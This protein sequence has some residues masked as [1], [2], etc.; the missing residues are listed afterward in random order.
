MILPMAFSAD[1]EQIRLRKQKQIN[2]DNIKENKSFLDYN[3]SVGDRVLTTDPISKEQKLERPT[4]GPFIVTRVHDNGTIRMQK[5]AV[6]E[7]M[8]IRRALPF[9]E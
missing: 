9:F 4:D 3:Y 6:D 2:K 8:N 1:W 5:G 7:T